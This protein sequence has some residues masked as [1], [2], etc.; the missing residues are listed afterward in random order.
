MILANVLYENVVN[1]VEKYWLH[2]DTSPTH[3]VKQASVTIRD[4]RSKPYGPN[5]CCTI[6]VSSCPPFFAYPSE[7]L[8]APSQPSAPYTS[9]SP[10]AAIS[11]AFAVAMAMDLRSFTPLERIAFTTII[12][13]AS[14]EIVSIVK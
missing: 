4:N 11:P 6:T 13:N 1:N 14:A 12:P 5:N 7:T 3:V 10:V 9:T 2:A 8:V